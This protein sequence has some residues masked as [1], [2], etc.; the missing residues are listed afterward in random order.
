M[1]LFKRLALA[2]VIGYMAARSIDV[3]RATHHRVEMG[4]RP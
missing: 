1:T 3:I 2:V 4:G